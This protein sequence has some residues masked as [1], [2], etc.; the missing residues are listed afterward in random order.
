ME[1][2]TKNTVTIEISLFLIHSAKTTH[3]AINP[4]KGGMPAKF[5]VTM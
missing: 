4:A 3:F 5:N 2:K 1:L